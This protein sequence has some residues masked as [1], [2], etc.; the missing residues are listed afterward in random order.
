[1][2]HLG[3]GKT[4]TQE[5]F[6]LPKEELGWFDSDRTMQRIEMTAAI[7]MPLNTSLAWRFCPKIAHFRHFRTTR[8]ADFGFLVQKSEYAS[9]AELNA[10]EA[11]FQIILTRQ[12]VLDFVRSEHSNRPTSPPQ[13]QSRVLYRA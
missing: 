2:E 8:I 6:Y 5:N 10:F 13:T 3:G 9:G 12:G 7:C 4:G 1:L 11:S